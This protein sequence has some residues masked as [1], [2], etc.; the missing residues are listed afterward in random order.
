MTSIPRDLWPDVTLPLLSDPYRYI[1]RRAR[2][3][4]TDAFRS[5]LIGQPAI[6][7]TGPEAAEF[8]YAPGCF[9]RQKAVPEHFAH[10]LFGDGGVQRLD[11][12]PHRHRKAL[13][14]DLATGDAPDRLERVVESVWIDSLPEFEAMS[15]I[16]VFPQT[17]RILTAAVC[18]WAGVPLPPHRIGSACEMLSSLFL[19]AAALGPEHLRGRQNR[20]AATLWACDLVRAARAPE[21]APRTDPVA[22]IAHWCDSTGTPLPDEAAATEV[23]NLLRPA[24]AVAVYVTFVAMALHRNPWHRARVAGDAAFRLA[25]VQEVRRLYPFFPAVAAWTVGAVAWRGEEIAAGT[26]A[27]LD[28][29]GTCRD[30]RSWPEADAFRPERFLDWPGDPWTLI[31]QGGGLHGQTHRCPGEDITIR[32]MALFARELARARYEVAT[33][34]ARPNYRAAPA[35]PKGG[36]QLTDFR[37]G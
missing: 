33:P 36:F 2:R 17:A 8:F 23:L 18:R 16:D 10:V 1:S 21:G 29:Y 14:L 5:R 4:G 32:L 26:R 15:A 11:A 24:V 7:L 25:F 6:F 12:E 30:P 3:M 35:L 34:D 27:V 19:H 20:K 37:A 22:R 13:W 9:H 28:L 31:P